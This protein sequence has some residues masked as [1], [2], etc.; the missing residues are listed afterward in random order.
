MLSAVTGRQKL[1]REG[2][3]R[4][5][6]LVLTALL[7]LSLS[8]TAFIVV[9]DWE[10]VRMREEF[11]RDARE[12]ARTLRDGL[13]HDLETLATVGAFVAASETVTGAGFGVFVDSVRPDHPAIVSI[14]WAPRETGA[15]GRAA[16]DAGRASDASFPIRHVVARAHGEALLGLDLASDP[17]SRVALAR[18]SETG[19]A[20]AAEPGTTLVGAAKRSDLTIFHPVYRPGAMP[21][22]ATGRNRSLIGIVVAV[23]GTD[24]AIES[25]LQ[26]RAEAKGLDIYVYDEALDRIRIDRTHI[27]GSIDPV[28][29]V[30]INEGEQIHAVDG[31][32]DGD[33]NQPRSALEAGPRL[34]HFHPSRLH[35]TH[36]HGPDGVRPLLEPDARSGL[37]LTRSFDVAGRQWTVLLRPA[38]GHS[39]HA[40]SLKEWQVLVAGLVITAILVAYLWI[41]SSRTRE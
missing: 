33:S 13:T 35:Q 20:T 19:K 34:M 6:H 21:R 40:A 1:R 38:A 11:R 41:L 36:D 27:V 26:T 31:L 3:S 2:G 14:A 4:P 23:L 29:P 18:M 24:D 15:E 37:H 5:L 16:G 30:T 22:G 28:N 25:A 7:G 8:L 10:L 17:A 9:R 32:A 12:D 39:I